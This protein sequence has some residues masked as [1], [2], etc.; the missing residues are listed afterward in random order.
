[1]EN[2]W[3]EDE[4]LEQIALYKNAL[5][6]LSHSQQYSVDG[7]TFVRAQLPEIRKT[8]KFFQRELE[9]LR[10]S[11]GPVLIEAVPRRSF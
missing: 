3:T 9:D 2:I 6:A 1:M 8:I 7:Q 5:A 4:L 11:G 10:R